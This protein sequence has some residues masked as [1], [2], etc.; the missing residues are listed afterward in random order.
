MLLLEIL[1]DID[2]DDHFALPP[3]LVAAV[4]EW[5]FDL[6]RAGIASLGGA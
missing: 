5:R 3:H 2:C 4:D 6:L 1:D